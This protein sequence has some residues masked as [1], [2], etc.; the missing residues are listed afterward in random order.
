MKNNI[1]YNNNKRIFSSFVI[2]I[3]VVVF[4]GVVSKN[5]YQLMLISGDS[6]EPTYHDKQLVIVDKHSQDYKYNDV[7]VFWCEELHS[8][9]VKRVVACPGDVVCIS[10]GKLYVNGK[11]SSVYGEEIVFLY[12]GIAEKPIYIGKDSYFV[13]GDNITQSKDSRYG[14]VGCVCKEVIRGKVL[15]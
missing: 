10:D 4:A 14:E 7:I 13:I 6:M 8:V 12:A 11:I 1:W 5:F 3:L 9:L 2:I 15:P